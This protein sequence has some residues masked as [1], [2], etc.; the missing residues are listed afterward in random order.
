MLAINL[1]PSQS[2]GLIYS[3]L[4]SR[5]VPATLA[6]LVT[7][8]SGHETAGWT[9]HVFMTDNNAFGYGYDGMSYRQYPGVEQ[10]VTD[11]VGYLHRR[12]AD[13][14]FPPLDQ[15]TGADQYAQLLKDAGY[16]TDSE[17]NYSAGIAAW[18]NANLGKIALGG[19]FFLL[20]FGFLLLMATRPK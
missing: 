9:S 14:S 11:I 19:S 3:T 6:Q 4:V 16:Y 5:G 2:E 15:I 10:S 13:G 1:S 7:A 12:V 8:Q 18:L 17:V 20:I